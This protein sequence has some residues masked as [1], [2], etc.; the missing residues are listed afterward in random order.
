[1]NISS[2]LYYK[3]IKMMIYASE[4]RRYWL[5][6]IKKNMMKNRRCCIFRRLSI[7]INFDG[8]LPKHPHQHPQCHPLGRIN[9]YNNMITKFILSLGLLTCT[10]I[11]SFSFWILAIHSRQPS[12]ACPQTL[13]QPF[14]SPLS[15][16][17]YLSIDITQRENNGSLLILLHFF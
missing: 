8:S 7:S 6:G 3:Y 10:L 16:A 13:E 9:S 12:T 2:I 17:L 15:F 1:M 11:S 4:G 14:T 5:V